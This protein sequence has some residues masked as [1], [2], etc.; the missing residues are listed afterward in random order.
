[1]SSQDNNETS[2]EVLEND[3]PSQESTTTAEFERPTI[4]PPTT[5]TTTVAA[6]ASSGHPVVLQNPVKIAFSYRQETNDRVKV[7]SALVHDRITTPDFPKPVF[8]APNFQA[9]LALIDAGRI[10]EFLSQENSRD[11]SSS[12]RTSVIETSTMPYSAIP[13]DVID[14]IHL[15]DT[16]EMAGQETGEVSVEAFE[17]YLQPDETINRSTLERAGVAGI[18][19]LD[20]G[21]M[22]SLSSTNGDFFFLYIEQ[23][24]IHLF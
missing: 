16:E 24:L 7:I 13:I 10:Y 8:Y 18:L 22:V 4:S 6:A 5:T 19:T 14:G 17:N 21:L 9:A 15:V 20:D 1:M 2:V 11:A 3:P 12:S 23:Q